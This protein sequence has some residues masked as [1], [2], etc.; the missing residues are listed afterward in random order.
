[1]GKGGFST[2]PFANLI[3]PI[4]C[5]CVREIP[6]WQVGRA[7]FH[8]RSIG[9]W[10][11]RVGWGP[12]IID[13]TVKLSGYSGGHIY[14]SLKQAKTPKLSL[15]YSLNVI[16]NGGGRKRHL[17]FNTRHLLWKHH[18]VFV[19][20]ISLIFCSSLLYFSPCSPDTFHWIYYKV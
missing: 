17:I 9:K 15:L 19:S 8:R 13:S 10:E 2:P 5:P 3:L 1:M 4:E 6:S 11:Q 18:L 7:T 16:I 20:H 14:L 12:G